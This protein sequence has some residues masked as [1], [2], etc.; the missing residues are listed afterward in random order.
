MLPCDLNLRYVVRGDRQGVV[1][2][3]NGSDQV[4]GIVLWNVF[5]KIPIARQVP[6]SPIPTHPIPS[7]CTVTGTSL[8]P[9]SNL[10]TPSYQNPHP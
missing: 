5:N 4:V 7:P 6:F 2:Y 9:P 10:F 1:F 8:S 3:L